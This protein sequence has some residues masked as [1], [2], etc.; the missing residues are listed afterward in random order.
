[1][2]VVS[3]LLLPGILKPT[4]N[5]SVVPTRCQMLHMKSKTQINTFNE[6]YHAVAKVGNWKGLCLNLA[7][8]D[9][10]MDEL[11]HSDL[12]TE[13]KKQDCL[14]TYWNT[15]EAIWETVIQ[16]VATYPISNIKLAIRIANSHNI[17][18]TCVTSDE[19]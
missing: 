3:A 15:N 19:F 4:V 5:F 18:Y 12:V 17:A 10:K 6:L 9:A 8:D 7:V 13:S 14:Q 1:M 16:A 2:I 11:K